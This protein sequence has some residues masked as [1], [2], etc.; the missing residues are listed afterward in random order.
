MSVSDVTADDI[1]NTWTWPEAIE[2]DTAE[3]S[4]S[5]LF[6]AD[7]SFWSG[8]FLPPPPRPPY[9]EDQISTDG[10]TTCDL[11]SWALERY[12]ESKPHSSG[13][14]SIETR[15]I[16]FLLRIEFPLVEERGG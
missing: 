6:R 10:L 11:C 15:Y 2:E 4:S 16:D 5:A 7:S 12:S 8:S 9:L 14:Y 13:E 3:I 1:D